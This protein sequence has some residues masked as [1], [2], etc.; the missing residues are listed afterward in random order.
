[1]IKAWILW[2]FHAA[3]RRKTL[4]QEHEGGVEVYPFQVQKLDRYLELGI[5]D[6]FFIIVD[7]ARACHVSNIHSENET[8]LLKINIILN[9]PPEDS[10]T[11]RKVE[12]EEAHELRVIAT[13]LIGNCGFL[14]TT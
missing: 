7:A 9:P 4:Q 2:I 10:H 8:Q 13:S 11:K 5:I 6:L 1:L 12:V 3:T 14:L